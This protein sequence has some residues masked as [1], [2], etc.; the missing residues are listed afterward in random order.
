MC[1]AFCR[2]FFSH[3]KS[4][5]NSASIGSIPS[6]AISHGQMFS[7]AEKP[8]WVSSEPILNEVW[9]EQN[10]LNKVTGIGAKWHIGVGFFDMNVIKENAIMARSPMRP[11]VLNMGETRESRRKFGKKLFDQDADSSAIP[12]DVGNSLSHD[13]DTTRINE[14]IS[15]LLL[16][17][18][19]N[20]ALKQVK[21]A[22]NSKR[23]QPLRIEQPRIKRR[24]LVVCYFRDRNGD[25]LTNA[26]LQSGF[27]VLLFERGYHK[28]F[29]DDENNKAKVGSQWVVNRNHEK[30]TRILDGEP[31]HY[32]GNK[33]T[34]QQRERR[35][36]YWENILR[37]NTGKL[38]G[39]DIDATTNRHDTNRHDNGTVISKSHVTNET[40]IENDRN[41][42]SAFIQSQSMSSPRIIRISDMNLF[43]PLLSIADGV[44][45]SAGNQLLSECLHSNMPVLAL[46]RENDGEQR[47]NIEMIR[48][49]HNRYRNVIR[50]MSIER[51]SNT[52]SSVFNAEY[53]QNED[54]KLFTEAEE[55]LFIRSSEAKEAY[56]DFNAYVEIVRK[57]VI[58]RSFYH[59]L[60][61]SILERNSMK[62][63]EFEQEQTANDDDT[64]EYGDP[65]QGMPEAAE[66]ILEIIN[67]LK[68][69]VKDQDHE[70]YQM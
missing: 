12:L 21:E 29:S 24:K 17:Q 34:I 25:A 49:K 11:E 19:L 61:A 22:V 45:S 36:A 38:L 70:G 6:I 20:S 4:S 56:D 63:G 7:I 3:L 18:E 58:S 43:V 8:S 31:Y 47:L 37:L 67:E 41:L 62:E 54:G 13:E 42:V 55:A 59:D 60:F 9:E 5:K 23:M 32:E 39:A 64:E 65:F 68:L 66:V 57:S 44:A 28:G 48:H 10:F 52:F 30:H 69:A 26:L 51:F 46:Y 53:K 40:N 14:H 35:V 50:G 15:D 27:D 1:T 2:P 33:T 16:G